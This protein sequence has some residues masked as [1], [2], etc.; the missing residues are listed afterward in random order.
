MLCHCPTWYCSFLLCF[1]FH[2]STLQRQPKKEPWH[3][4]VCRVSIPRRATWVGCSAL[5]WIPNTFQCSFW[6]SLK[7]LKICLSWH[8]TCQKHEGLRSDPHYPCKFTGMVIYTYNLSA[9]E[10]DH[11]SSL[12]RGSNQMSEL[13]VSWYIPS[14]NI[15]QRVFEETPGVDPWPPHACAYIYNHTYKF[16][17]TNTQIV[18]DAH[19]SV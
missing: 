13:Q 14:Q 4:Q 7:G 2:F 12:A 3:P 5:S 8:H 18:R 16:L 6:I 11:W 17:H 1:I 10:D 19:T 9:G 15:R